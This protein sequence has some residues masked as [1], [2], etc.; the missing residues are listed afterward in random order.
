M[1]IFGAFLIVGG[2]FLIGAAEAGE[3]SRGCRLLAASVRLLDALLETLSW[4]RE[5][6]GD[7]FRRYRDPV[8]EESGFSEMLCGET[9]VR[10][11]WKRFFAGVALEAEAKEALLALGDTLGGV[12][13]E[14]QSERIR[15]CKAVCEAVLAAESE[16][17]KKLRKS[18]TAVWTLVGGLVALALL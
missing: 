9:G 12:G 17:E 14:A 7:F 10:D 5:P 15:R 11:G 13:L 16:K 1:S 6:L 3:R 18:T 2:F 4:A 8:L